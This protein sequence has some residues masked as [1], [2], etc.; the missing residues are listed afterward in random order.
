VVTWTA[1]ADDDAA[2]TWDRNL[3]QFAERSYLQRVG[4]GHYKATQGWTPVRAAAYDERGVIVGMVQALVRTYPG[5]FGVI[6]CPGGHVGPLTLW[7]RNLVEALSQASAVRRVYCRVSFPRSGTA[8]DAQHLHAV[9]W[10]RPSQPVSAPRTLIWDL[11]AVEDALR[12]GLS[13]NWRHNLNRALRRNLRVVEWHDPS[14]AAVASLFDA[15]ATYKDLDMA[16]DPSAIDAMI[17]SLDGRMLI[18]TCENEAGAPIAVRGCVIDGDSAWDLLAATSPEGRRCYASY[19]VLWA[20]VRSCRERKVNT[21]D[22]GGIDPEAAPGVYTFKRGTGAREQERLG[23]WE[24]ST[25][26]LLAGAV[27]LRLRLSRRAAF[28]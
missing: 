5:G 27:G 24:W 25:S 8:A 1:V 11:S 22:L 13:D 16:A 26:R 4:W 12:A 3:E 28:A 7:N 19:A 10:R 21:Y 9:G 18:Y 14:P 17:R 2:R 15:M 23:E 6:W 20:L